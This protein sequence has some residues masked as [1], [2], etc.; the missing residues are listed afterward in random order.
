[1]ATQENDSTD[2]EVV[3]KD[4]KKIMNSDCS[5]LKTLLLILSVFFHVEVVVTASDVPNVTIPN[6]EYSIWSGSAMTLECIIDSIPN[7]TDV[8]WQKESHGT[9]MNI[10]SSSTNVYGATV[11]KPSLTITHVTTDD[12]G[13]YICLAVN[14]VGTG[15]SNPTSVKVLGKMFY[16]FYSDE[17]Y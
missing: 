12:E 3:L 15:K 10:T 4:L 17:A 16:I 5:V 6:A 7:H 9:V 2:I 8:Y 13:Q 14:I 11:T 1:M